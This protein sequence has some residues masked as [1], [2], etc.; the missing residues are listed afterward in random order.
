MNNLYRITEQALVRFMSLNQHE[1]EEKPLPH[2]WSKKEILGHLVDS[3][4]N[5]L[6]RFTEIQYY[7]TPYRVIPYDQDQLVEANR[8]QSE[9]LEL[10]TAMWVSLN[11]HIAYIIQSLDQKSMELAVILPEGTE[12][13]LQ[14][15]VQDYIDHLLHH[16]DQIYSKKL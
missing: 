2:K 1:W 8:Y 3:A 13:D 9:S 15:L 12:T 4:R 7:T 14:W 5:N 10:I 11:R 6:Q 16:L